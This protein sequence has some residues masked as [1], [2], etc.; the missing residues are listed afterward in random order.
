MTLFKNLGKKVA[1]FAFALACGTS[2]TYA[3]A[4]LNSEASCCRYDCADAYPGG[5]SLYKAC[6]NTCLA[7][8]W[9]RN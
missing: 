1:L 3:S 8:G 4:S 6:Y 2:W 5:G 7:E 9:C